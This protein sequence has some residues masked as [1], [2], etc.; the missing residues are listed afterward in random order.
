MAKRNKVKTEEKIL[1]ESFDFEK[2]VKAGPGGVTEETLA[3]AKA[4]ARAV[5]EMRARK[6]LK[7]V[8]YDADLLEQVQKLANDEGIPYQTLMN[9]LLKAGLESRKTNI[10]KRIERIERALFKNHG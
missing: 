9:S 1:S 4:K 3:E 10:I 6:I 7:S 5:D 8:R 2:A